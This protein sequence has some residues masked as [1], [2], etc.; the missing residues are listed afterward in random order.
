MKN[1]K[2]HHVLK[3]TK[4]S[5]YVTNAKVTEQNARISLLIL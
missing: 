1:N 5:Q 4:Q 2:A 3:V